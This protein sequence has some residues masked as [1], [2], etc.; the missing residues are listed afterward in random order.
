MLGQKDFVTKS[1]QFLRDVSAQDQ[2][3]DPRGIDFDSEH[4]RLFVTDSHW[5]RLLVFD[6]PAARHELSMENDGM[7]RR[8]TL[9]PVLA[10]GKNERR[11]GYAL[12]R[13]APASRAVAIRTSTHAITNDLTEQESRMLVSQTA[14]RAASTSRR[15]LV[16]LD[17]SSEIQLTNPGETEAQVELTW[18]RDGATTRTTTSLLR[19]SSETLRETGVGTLV[20]ESAT[21]VAALAWRHENNL[22]GEGITTALPVLSAG[23]SSRAVPN[24]TL[25]GGYQT[26]LVLVHTGS[27]QAR[28]EVVLFDEEG[29]EARRSAYVIEAD[30]HWRWSLTEDR[31]VPRRYYA[32]LVGDA[33]AAT[34]LVRRVDRG[35]ITAT[36]RE[37]AAMMKRAR[38]PVDTMPDLV[39][40]GR[41]TEL[42]IVIANADD[43]GASVRFILRDLD[44]REVDRVEQLLMPRV[45][46]ELTL[47]G[48]FDRRRFAGTIT[49]V[50]DVAVALSARQ[51][52]TNLRGDAILTELPIVE[53][54]RSN[55]ARVLP[56]IDGEGEST[57]WLVF[58][59]NAVLEL[60]DPS[61]KP[62][63][64]LLR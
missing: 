60:F 6:F 46:V 51:V 44:G 49:F 54:A 22:H 41:A 28:G 24:I 55:S 14:S 56:Y 42:R 33:A 38:L 34:T 52:T 21:P 58:G 3:Y 15:F 19:G 64:A 35:L 37:P 31:A 2:L 61:G 1:D 30:K 23:I 57:Q 10:L 48:L 7:R 5:A 40:H 4:G 25:G 20:V 36:S 12:L 13:D 43:R 8:S 62:L 39:R 45:Q 50:S 17:G 59:G 11:W 26:D 18:H 9:D 53:D 29:R 27:G 63:P 47:A 32:V 16:L